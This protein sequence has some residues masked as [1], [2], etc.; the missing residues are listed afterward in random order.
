MS[1][2][3]FV[4]DDDDDLSLQA[5]TLAGQLGTAKVVRFEGP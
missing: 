5:V 4:E 1:V 2:L 3:V